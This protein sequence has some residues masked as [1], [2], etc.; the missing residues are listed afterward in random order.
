MKQLLNGNSG[1]TAVEF[2]LVAP[3][4]LLVIFGTW[5]AGVLLFAQNGI[6]N[7][8]ETGARAATV[9]PRPSE[10]AIRQLTS[11]AYYGP[12]RANL[13]G[14][15]LSYSV[16]N[17]APVV[18]ITMSYRHESFVPFLSIAPVTLTHQRTSY[19]APQGPSGS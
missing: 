16:R 15:T 11:N 12:S 9:F 14:P 6:R 1:A 19:L 10:T 18:N 7:A 4:F 13:T 8:V 5:N 3:L 17:G 2:A